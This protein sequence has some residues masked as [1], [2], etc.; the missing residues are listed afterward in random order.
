MA[1]LY[2]EGYISVGVIYTLYIYFGND[3]EPFISLNIVKVS[4]LSL[5]W[6]ASPDLKYHS[7]E[8][9]EVDCGYWLC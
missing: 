2:T 4:T 1:I 6:S 5:A 7:K 3:L 9:K 8:E